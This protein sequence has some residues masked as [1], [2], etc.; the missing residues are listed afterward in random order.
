MCVTSLNFVPS[1]PVPVPH[2]AAGH[3]ASTGQVDRFFSIRKR[4]SM[5]E[6]TNSSVSKLRPGNAEGQGAGREA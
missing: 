6:E 4:F 2:A 5:K 1:F 3:M